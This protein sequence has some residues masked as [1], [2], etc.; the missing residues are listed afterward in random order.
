MGDII[1]TPA[2]N[3]ELTGKGLLDDLALL[4]HTVLAVS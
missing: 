3:P 4:T 1:H 2:P